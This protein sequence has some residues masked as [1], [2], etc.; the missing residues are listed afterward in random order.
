MLNIKK[1]LNLSI[2][3]T[4]L[5]I[6]N[7]IECIFES[8]LNNNRITIY[9]RRTKL[10]WLLVA[11]T[12]LIPT[13]FLI[14]RLQGKKLNSNEEKKAFNKTAPTHLNE[15]QNIINYNE[16]IHKE[17]LAIIVRQ[18]ADFLW[19]TSGTIEQKTSRIMSEL[20][21]K[22]TKIL[23]NIDKKP[24]GFV[25]FYINNTN[26]KLYLLGVDENYQ[27]KGHGKFILQYAINQLKNQNAKMIKIQVQKTNARAKQLYEKIGF[28]F[29]ENTL[30][31]KSRIEGIYTC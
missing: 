14:M 8:I 27:G 16:T 5:L 4:V 26:G 13:S 2:F 24:I 20:N 19:D 25:N 7:P 31:G 23:I 17:A 10:L 21:N 22:N 6:Y 30:I 3:L 12:S 9:R 1:K 28:K 18:G 29:N 11:S 15:Y